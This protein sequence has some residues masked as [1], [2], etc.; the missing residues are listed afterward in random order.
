MVKELL[1]NSL[2]AGAD[3][4]DIYVEGGGSALLRVADNGCGMD[5]DDVLLCLER[6]A[7]SKLGEGS[8]LAGN[9]SAIDTLGFRGEA[10]PSI[11]SVSRMT[12][13][14]RLRGHE[15]GTK[16]EIRYGQ[17]QAVHESGC[18]VGTQVEVRHLFGNM[19]VRK[20]F[21]KSAR[22]EILH[23]EEVV[24]SHALAHPHVGFRLYEEQRLGLEYLASADLEKRVRQVFS[25]KDALLM[26]NPKQDMAENNMRLQGFLLLPQSAQ[27]ARARLRI[28]VNKRPVQDNMIRHAV[29]TG[30]AGFLMK[31]YQP[32]GVLLLDLPAEMVDVN[33]HPA[34]REVRFRRSEDVHR[35]LVRET[36]RAIQAYQD[37]LRTEIFILPELR[38]HTA[39][40]SESAIT[41]AQV[42]DFFVNQPDNFI[43]PI[44]AAEDSPFFGA[45]QLSHPPAPQQNTATTPLLLPTAVDNAHAEQ[46]P[47]SASQPNEISTGLRFIGQFLDLYLLCARQDQLVIIDQHAAHERLLYMELRQ[48][49]LQ[50]RMARQA[51]LLPVTV[52][53][54]PMQMET[55]EQR[56]NEVEALGF[57]IVMFGG[58][59]CLVKALPA[60]LVAVDPAPLLMEILDSLRGMSAREAGQV[61]PAPIDALLASMACKAAIKA[62]NRLQPEEIRALL[63]QMEE[64]RVFSHCPHGRPVLRAF[65]RREVEKWFHRHGEQRKN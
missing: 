7:T 54:S 29:R 43:W 20:K 16:A 24:K 12:I 42:G 40:Q 46:H 15:L 23:I 55:L 39:A 2:D 51:L 18:A 62:G 32:S 35:F 60:S 17:M 41:T 47:A 26:L 5:S 61:L 9:L 13:L 56:Q 44:T 3:Q 38:E 45:S 6:H 25:Y 53:L 21:L 19:P 30:M 49:Y 31:G 1:E 52:E 36:S 65:D 27:T 11:A 28:L 10:M 8:G 64:A 33:V 34:K 63:Q 48:S 14:S 58:T 50:S 37:Q 4:I 57:E 22:T 59:T